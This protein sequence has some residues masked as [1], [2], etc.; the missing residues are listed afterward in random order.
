MGSKTIVASGRLCAY[1]FNNHLSSSGSFTKCIKPNIFRLNHKTN[2]VQNFLIIEWAS[3]RLADAFSSGPISNFIYDENIC[4]MFTVVCA[5]CAENVSHFQ[6]S[7][8]IAVAARRLMLRDRVM[9][10]S[11]LV[12][13][14]VFILFDR[15]LKI[16]DGANWLIITRLLWRMH[17]LFNWEFHFSYAIKYWCDVLIYS[18][19]ELLSTPLLH[20]TNNCNQLQSSWRKTKWYENILMY[21]CCAHSS[22]HGHPK[23]REN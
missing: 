6:S 3:A 15:Y 14:F 21:C 12:F 23:I 8:V 17:L 5:E 16:R 11:Y 9:M 1:I 7:W 18:K 4:F 13:V 10:I 2:T 19:N 20:V 22:W